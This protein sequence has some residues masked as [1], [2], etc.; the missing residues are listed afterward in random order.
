MN[1]EKYFIDLSKCSESEIKA[2]ALVM[3]RTKKLHDKAF[4]Y[5]S[6][7]KTF[8]HFICLAQTDSKEWTLWNQNALF[9]KTELTYPEFIKFF[10]GEDDYPGK[11]CQPLFDYLNQEH[12]L[13]LHES[14]MDEIIRIETELN[15]NQ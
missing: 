6:K 4:N 3:M 13:I 8:D 14:E 11:R 15:S 5:M 12:G 1:K 10:E 7:G 9:N 2:L